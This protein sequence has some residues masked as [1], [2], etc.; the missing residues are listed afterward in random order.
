MKRFALALA[1]TFGIGAAASAQQMKWEP[2]TRDPA[3][4]VAGDYAV[5]PSHTRVMFGV[6]HMGFT[7]YYGN[8]TGASGT[9]HFAPTNPAAMQV[10]VSVPVATV[11][12]T[13][14]KLDGEL[15]SADWL[16]AGKFPTMTFKSTSVTQTG[17]S[18]ADVTGDL[19]LHGV[20][21]SVVF[22]TI[23]NGG[24]KNPLDQK[25]TV[26]FQASARIK[27]SDFGVSTYV[28]MIG[29]EVLVILSAAFEKS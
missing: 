7:M 16:D 6:M 15:K 5:E 29:D 1:L 24:G 2:P 19:T 8:F 14:A 13:N 9:L 27:R 12:T 17:A 21:K 26:G 22:H 20:T 10:A 11:T 4:L 18:M 3:K 25:A 23:F 28:P